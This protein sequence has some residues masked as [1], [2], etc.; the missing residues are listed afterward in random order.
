MSSITP[1][2]LSDDRILRGIPRD[3]EGR[4][5]LGG[6]PLLSRLGKGSTSTV[7]YGIHP[8][9][10]VEV[11]VKVLSL[12][13]IE[14]DP[15]MLTRFLNEARIAA[16]IR[17]PYLVSVL[18]VNEEHGLNYLVLEYVSGLSLQDYIRDV[19]K[20]K[21]QLFAEHDALIVIKA[22]AQGLWAAHR[23]GVV[24]RDIK[25]ANILIPYLADNRTLD[26]NGAKITDLGLA[27]REDGGHQFTQ[28]QMAM[29]TPGFMAPE[30]ASDAKRVGPSSDIFG[31]GATF[32]ALLAGHPPFRGDTIVATLVKTVQEEPEPLAPTRSDISPQTQAII[33]RCLLKEP[34]LRYADVSELL[35]ALDAV[36]TGIPPIM[37]GPGTQDV[38]EDAPQ[39]GTIKVDLAVMQQQVARSMASAKAV[40]TG[41]R[42]KTVL[43]DPANQL[44]TI[45]TQVY[46]EPQTEPKWMLD[47]QDI[48]DFLY[49]GAPL[50]GLVKQVNEAYALVDLGPV[51]GILRRSRVLLGWRPPKPL[52]DLLK[53]DERIEVIISDILP[54]K[55]QVLLEY[56]HAPQHMALPAYIH[57][58]AVVRGR[59]TRLLPQ[60]AL[61]D[62]GGIVGMLPYATLKFSA[63]PGESRKK[64]VQEGQELF[65]RVEKI[66]HVN[67]RISLS[68]QFEKS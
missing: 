14:H 41:N 27:K 28:T 17:S 26:L 52:P 13:M 42:Q 21:R 61:I 39:D 48:P 54:R 16:R 34:E 25:P 35:A 45:K 40:A 66:D 46:A 32:Y 10:D 18:D 59:V 7:Y 44:D 3:E 55:H 5:R 43:V 22:A 57:Y 62:L 9:L 11:A 12:Q 67:L 58:G 8:R 63:T 30:Q 53:I 65:V 24:H 4:P 31:L 47:E 23:Q 56:R 37:P 68:S 33:D 19:D 20:G 2:D 50:S 15:S 29:G 1:Q 49:V 51:D 64:P 6:I 38:V 36:L 60:G